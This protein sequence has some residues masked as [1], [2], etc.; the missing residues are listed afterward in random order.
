MVNDKITENLIYVIKNYKSRYG[1]NATIIEFENAILSMKNPNLSYIFKKETG[2]KRKEHEYIISTSWDIDLLYKSAVEFK[3]ID[4]EIIEE[5]IL[6]L[7][8]VVEEDKY[9]K[10]LSLFIKNVP[11]C[12]KEKI[13]EEITSIKRE[14]KI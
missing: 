3:D 11:N 2:T 7:K 6:G 8:D 4:V 1:V 10:Y 13:K 14:R 9:I 12:D 5:S